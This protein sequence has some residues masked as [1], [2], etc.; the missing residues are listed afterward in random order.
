MD[1]IKAHVK[2]LWELL[3]LYPRDNRKSVADF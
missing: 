3:G 1:F 2:Q